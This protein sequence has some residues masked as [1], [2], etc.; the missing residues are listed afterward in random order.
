MLF[1]LAMMLPLVASAGHVTQEQAKSEAMSFLQQKRGLP[2]S[3]TVATKASRNAA[4]PAGDALYYVF[5][6]GNNGGFVIVS[7]DDRTNPILGFSDEGAFDPNNVPSNMQSWLEGYAEQIQALDNMSEAQAKTLLAAPRLRSTVDTRNSIAPMITTKWNQATPYWNKCPEFMSVE[8]G[9]TIGELAYTGCVATAMS[10]IMNYYKYPTDPTSTIPAYTFSYNAGNYNY[11]TVSMPA[12]DPITFDWAHM[13]DSYTG[14]EDQVYTDAVANLMLYVGCAIKSQYG[15]SATGAYT[16]DIPNGFGL[17][18]YGSNLAYRNDYTQEVWDNMVYEELA[19]GRPMVYNG[20]AGSGG[21]HSFICDGYEYGDDFHINWGWGGMGNGYFQLAILNPSTSGIGGSSSA[22]GYNM[23]QNIVYNIQPGGTTPGDDDELEPALTCTAISGPSGWDRDGLS[24]PFKIYKSK[25]VK[26]SYSDHENSG[27]KF[28]TALAMLDPNTG[29]FTICENSEGTGYF[30]VTTSA[31]GETR[32]FGSGI[33]SNASNVIKFGANMTGTYHLVGVYQ[34]EG[35]SEWKLMK[36]SDRYYMEVNMTNYSATADYHP[37]I[38]LAVTNWEFTGGERVGVKEQVNVTLK[39][40]SVDR[41]YGDLYLDF[42][43]Q[44]ID[45]Y[46]QYTTVV[47]GEVL[48]GEENVITFNVTPTSSGT[49]TVKI[50]RLD[51][52]GSLVTIASTT[53]NIAQSAEAEELNLSVVIQ[54]ENATTQ[55]SGSNIYGEIYDSHAHFSATITNHSNGEYN[56]YVL[57]PLFIITKNPDGT[58]AGGSMVTYKQSALSLAAGES[59]TLYFDFDDLAYGSTYAMNIYARNYVPDNQEGTHIENIVKPGHSVYYDIKPGI[60]TWTAEGVR[61]GYQP[62][63]NFQVAADVAA[64]NLEG[65]TLNS[66]VPNSNPNTLYFV[67]ENETAPSSLTGKNIVTGNTAASIALTDGYPYF[68]PMSFTA[69][70]ISYERTFDKARQDGVA[71]NWSTIVL[72]FT[73][74]T[75]SASSNNMW[76]ENFAQ[77]VDGV[78]T[79]SEV[80]AI[81]ANVP[82]IIAINKAAN[83]IGTPITWSASNV[84]LKPEPIAY[85]SGETYL[86]AGTFVGETVADAYTVDAAGAV[87]KWGNA[88]VQPFRAYFSELEALESHTDIELPGEASTTTIVGDVNGDGDVNVID[89]TALIDVIMNDDTSNPRADVNGDGE[90]NVIDITALID[91]IMNM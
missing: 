33:Q 25:I 47:T 83:L 49:K 69:Q 76:I 53:V 29:S 38:N 40:N 88:T 3:L 35:T 26:V 4:V 23:K 15:T 20:T 91:I 90:I 72:P 51:A 16:D 86:M 54:A 14:A 1:L 21:G 48:P 80:N 75:C 71:E 50:M 10:Q 60:I 64:V 22:E 78:V 7:G 62:V 30:T 82:Y 2:L 18:G 43:G 65:L 41:Y 79:F 85:T 61:S 87:A 58:V 66:I 17:F 59:K 24:Y 73:P 56:K 34:L 6:I 77:E 70:T 68:T 27:K 45:E 11:V 36:E 46:S 31:L 52:Y 39:N 28:K 12:L 84:L 5:N 67:G 13:R 8:D 74:A 81:E 55:P 37:T 57:A 44:Q 19:A 32:Q 89:I 9:D 63:E 42:G